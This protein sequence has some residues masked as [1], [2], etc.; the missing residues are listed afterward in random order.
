MKKHHKNISKKI[1]DCN[2][3]ESNYYLD[4]IFVF[5]FIIFDL[6]WSSYY[7]SIAN[8]Q[9]KGSAAPNIW[10]TFCN[11]ELIFLAHLRDEKCAI[12]F[13]MQIGA[14]MNEAEIIDPYRLFKKNL[15]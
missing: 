14:I 2:V 7:F 15:D 12:N 8:V 13:P 3:Q 9:C 1:T 5:F 11:K 6:H 4:I 10:T